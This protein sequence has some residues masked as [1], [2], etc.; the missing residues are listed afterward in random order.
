MTTTTALGLLPAEL[1]GLVFSS[2]HCNE[3]MKLAL[4]HRSFLPLTRPYLLGNLTLCSLHPDSHERVRVILTNPEFGRYVRHLRIEH[5]PVQVVHSPHWRR[6][7][8]VKYYELQQF[9]WRH[10]LRSFRR[11]ALTHKTSIKT[12]EMVLPYLLNAH[13][14]TVNLQ[15]SHTIPYPERLE[16]L[17]TKCP[18]I[19]I[20]HLQLD[21]LH[22]AFFAECVEKDP[23]V[24]NQLKELSLQLFRRSGCRLGTRDQRNNISVVFDACRHSLKVLSLSSHAW[25]YLIVPVLGKMPHLERFEWDGTQSWMH[26][27]D[28]NC[29]NI[30]NFLRLHKDTLRHVALLGFPLGMED[31]WFSP[32]EDSNMLPKLVTL[33][34]DC[35]SGMLRFPYPIPTY[36]TPFADTLEVLYLDGKPMEVEAITLLVLVLHKPLGGARLKALRVPVQMLRV[37]L[38][39]TLA[40]HLDNLQTLEVAYLGGDLLSPV[41]RASFRLEMKVRDFSHWSLKCLNILAIE[42]DAFSEKHKDSAKALL[43]IVSGEIPSVRSCEKIDWPE[44]LDLR[45]TSFTF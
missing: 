30:L 16:Q 2:L 19:Q 14:V 20:L 24:L 23:M 10:P 28:S 8:E 29:P 41:N 31:Q 39:T 44:I 27:G 9:K 4:V 34:L 40:G 3:V 1:W 43:E 42:G 15:H 37:S 6:A 38:F 5:F 21:S 11:L 33:F 25:P 32:S 26:L 13:K 18:P 45:C 12:A 17:W 22:S 36:V 35:Q 7:L